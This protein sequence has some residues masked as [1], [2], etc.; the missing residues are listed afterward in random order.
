[1]ASWPS[2]WMTSALE[3]AGVPVTPAALAVL[4]A[5]KDSTPIPPY[6]NNPVGMP[7]GSSGA[8]R[9]L[10]TG[11]GMFV[12]IGNF[13]SAFAA[14]MRTDAGKRIAADMAMEVPYAAAWRDISRLKWPGTDTETDYPSAL[15]DLTSEAYQ[16]SVHATPAADRKT[17]GQVIARGD[18]SRTVLQQQRSVSEAVNTITG[19][20]NQVR[21]LLRRHGGTA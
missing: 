15:L 10:S 14:F 8:I 19:V 5:W 11:Y 17:S 20:E 16:K 3:A 4:K 12:T 18:A 6:S 1:M 2:T 9:Y 7:Y 13:Y 21:F